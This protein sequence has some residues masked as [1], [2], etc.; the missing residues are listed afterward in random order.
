M[1]SKG[2]K[3]GKLTAET[4]HI[5]QRWAAACAHVHQCGTC[6]RNTVCGNLIAKLAGKVC[7]LT[8]QE[9]H[10]TERWAAACG[11]VHE[12]ASCPLSAACE[13]LAD[14]LVARCHLI[15]QSGATAYKGRVRLRSKE[16]TC[17]T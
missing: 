2:G 17:L 7:R 9:D 12:C 1:S 15:T 16:I 10:V 5:V 3:G 11:H 8:A 14:K 13:K 4:D 6:S